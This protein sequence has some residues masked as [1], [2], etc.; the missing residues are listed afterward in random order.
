VFDVFPVETVYVAG[1]PNSTLTYDTFSRGVG[2]EG[3]E[4]EVLRTGALMDLVG[5]LGDV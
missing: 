1:A 3:A 5:V 2:E 4:A